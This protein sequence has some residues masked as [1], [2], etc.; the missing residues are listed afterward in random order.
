[1]ERRRGALIGFKLKRGNLLRLIIICII[2]LVLN[3]VV[4]PAYA[5]NDDGDDR[6]VGVEW[7]NQYHGRAGDL[8]FCDDDAGGFY[9]VLLSRGFTGRFNWGDYLAWESDFEKPN[10]GGHDN[11]WVD[12]VDYAYFSGHGSQAT[13]HFGTNHDGDGTWTFMVYTFD[14]AEWGDQDLEWMFASACEVL[15]EC[16]LQWWRWSYVFDNYLHGVTGFWTVSADTPVLGT[17]FANYLT[18]VWGPNSI[19]EAWRLATIRDEYQPDWVEACVLR[20]GDIDPKWGFVWYDY[21]LDRLPG[22][23]GQ[24]DEHWWPWTLLETHWRCG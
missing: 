13:F 1:M 21:W 4:L 7:V 18:D 6:E 24:G 9:N 5:G 11:V 14:E 10:V 12:A 22:Y 2:Y 8:Q 20:R 23:G 15:R 16:N 3:S 19:G 17:Y